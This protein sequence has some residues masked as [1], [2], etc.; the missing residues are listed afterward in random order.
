M[1]RNRAFLCSR[2]GQNQKV[3]AMKKRAWGKRN[4]E[5]RIKVGQT[6]I[7]C[8]LMYFWIDYNVL[9]YEWELR[10][11]DRKFSEFLQTLCNRSG[12]FWAL[13]SSLIFV[14]GYT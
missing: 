4:N 9:V 11:A 14:L 3:K 12:Y 7:E 5:N 8:S 13:K 6:D 1:K 10:L 2:I